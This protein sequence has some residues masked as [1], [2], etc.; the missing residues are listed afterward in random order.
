MNGCGLV[1]ESSTSNSANNTTELLYLPCHDFLGKF[2]RFSGKIILSFTPRTANEYL[3]LRVKL[4]F[5]C[6]THVSCWDI[7]RN[8]NVRKVIF[9][10]T[11]VSK[12]DTQ[13]NSA[14]FLQRIMVIITEKKMFWLF[15]EGGGKKILDVSFCIFS[16]FFRLMAK[17]DKTWHF[18]AKLLRH[19]SKLSRFSTAIFTQTSEIMQ[20]VLNQRL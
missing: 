10:P 19:C 12:Y 6:L 8:K 1:L 11:A 15:L 5:I 9:L 14:G 4:G 20:K 17:I 13:N 18:Q 16:H 7:N 2:T 3:G